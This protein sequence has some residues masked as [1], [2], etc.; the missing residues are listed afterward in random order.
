LAYVEWFSAFH[1]PE[2][3][4]SLY[5]VSCIIMNEQCLASVIPINNVHHSAH[6]ILHLGHVAPCDWTSAN[7]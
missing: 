3:N 5:K 4:H 1:A 2:H 7:V 6:L